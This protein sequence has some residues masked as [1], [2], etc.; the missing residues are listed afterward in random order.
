VARIE[1]EKLLLEAAR[2]AFLAEVFVTA[3]H[4][5]PG[6]AGEL[7]GGREPRLR[8]LC[9]ERGRC[10]QAHEETGLVEPLDIDPRCSGKRLHRQQK[11]EDH[12][13]PTQV[14]IS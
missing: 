12:R 6:L 3:E 10:R 5:A 1:A 2:L 13:Y 8:I 4:R 9:G 7:C 14:R 11:P